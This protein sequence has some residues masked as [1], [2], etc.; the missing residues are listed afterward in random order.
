M[1]N[2]SASINLF[3]KTNLPAVTK[4]IDASFKKIGVSSK[5]T[6][7]ALLKNSE[8]INRMGA[9]ANRAKIALLG[10][11]AVGIGSTLKFGMDYQDALQDLSSLT[12]L[13]GNDLKLL[14]DSA[15][16]TGKK[17][18]VASSKILET[19]KI[20]A[21]SMPALLKQPVLLGKV[22]DAAVLLGKASRM[23]LGESTRAL[24]TTIN[25]FNLTGEEASRVVN[26]LAAG[27]KEGAG[28]IPY[29]TEAIE[30]A[31]TTFAATGISIEDGVALVESIAPKFAKASQAG[32][33]L[34]KVFLKIKDCLLYTSDAADE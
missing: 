31:G 2:Y 15:L 28:D 1:A 33:S 13:V 34:D 24:T 7:A 17:Y 29:I 20:I 19:N 14:G 10:M 12:G 4:Q 16:I 6:Q 25:Q 11:A 32:N 30:K 22:T 27:A 3:G 5:K 18:G 23:D 9:A 8:A 21:S 26:A